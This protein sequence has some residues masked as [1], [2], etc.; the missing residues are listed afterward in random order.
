MDIEQIFATLANGT[1]LRC[2]ALVASHDEICVCE[3]VDTLGISQSSA[4][5]ALAALKQAGFL[6]DRRD[7]NWNYYRRSRHMPP[8]QEALLDSTLQH[9]RTTSP[10]RDDLGHFVRQM[11][12]S[13]RASSM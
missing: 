6:M 3:I 1:R 2:L 9:L 10:Y 5:K 7:A 4:S 12:R 8:W 13:A 11:K